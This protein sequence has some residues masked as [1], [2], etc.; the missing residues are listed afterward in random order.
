MVHCCSSAM[1]AV[2]DVSCKTKVKIM[3]CKVLSCAEPPNLLI[4]FGANR[5]ISKEFSVEP[6]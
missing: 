5:K 6:L 2:C 3:N 1:M 4:N